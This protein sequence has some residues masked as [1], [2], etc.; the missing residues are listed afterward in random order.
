MI[1][2]IDFEMCFS[3]RFSRENGEAHGETRMT[4]PQIQSL[5]EPLEGKEGSSHAKYSGAP[6]QVSVN[7]EGL[8][9][10]QVCGVGKGLVMMKCVTSQISTV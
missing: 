4:F 5:L 2:A 1:K 3:F 7:N 8:M 10:H 9:G 6:L